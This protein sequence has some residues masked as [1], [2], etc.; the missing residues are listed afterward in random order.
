[1][2]FSRLG[3]VFSR[4][5]SLLRRPLYLLSVRARIATLAFSP[6]LGFMIIGLAY[7]VGEHELESAFDSVKSAS[8]LADVSRD[9]KTAIGTM[10]ITA[11]E[12][13]AQPETNEIKTFSEAYAAALKSLESIEVGGEAS[14]KQGVG[15]LRQ[16]LMELKEKF[17]AMQ[18]EAEKLGL[19]ANEG[20]RGRV[21]KNSAAVERI[22]NQEMSWLSDADQKKLLFSLLIMRRYEADYRL[23]RQDIAHSMFFLEFQNFNSALGRMNAVGD[24]IA[25]ASLLKR[26][27]T[28]QVRS[29]ADT[30]GEWAET[31]D[32]VKPS[33]AI[34]ELDSAEMLPAADKIIA[35]AGQREEE[36]TARFDASQMRTKWIILSA[37]FA[38][39]LLGLLLSWLIGRSIT[40]PLGGLASAM[41][42]LAEGNLS[43]AVP[44]ARASDE[45]G[46]MAR[47]VLVFRDN[48]R[49]R[50]RLEAEQQHTSAEREA[51]AAAVERLVRGFAGTADLALDAVKAAA[52]KLGIAA[53]G[54]GET[55]GR[56]GSEAEQAGRAAGAA[57]ANVAQAA[58][59]AEQ[60]A[61]SV[62]EV[63][64]QTA[65]S[66]EV[67]GRAV[68][69]T[70]RSVGIM[71]TLAEAASR[72]GEVVGLIQ[73][74]AAQTNLLALNATIEAARAGEAGRGFAVV[75]AEVKSLA[76]QTAHATEE[77]TYQ[78]NAIQEASFEARRAIDTVSSVIQEMSAMA[79]SIAS[80]VEEQN[81]AVVSIANNVALASNEADVGAN[82]MR[83][84]EHAASGARL[85]ASDVAALAVQLGGEAENLNAAIGKFLAEVRAA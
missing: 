36:A 67:A 50:D 41:K 75:A 69:E 52:N 19:S 51:H 45:I 74:I 5:G 79:A 42:S 43:A 7:V 46:A 23:N 82:A 4:L 44:A 70:Q 38:V 33:L 22:I 71:G 58:A 76:N 35:L 13:A 62:A 40:R 9:F 15:S 21:E 32:R 84:V 10:R 73:S 37:G 83:G 80:A 78:I 53:D 12:F 81:M 31:D 8:A 6:V 57:S 1:M 55:A 3:S 18:M 65:S 61:G 27:L 56:V 68:T 16:R 24:K 20:L 77:I 14:E 29:Y 48:A 39:A 2:D 17:S 30:F 72:I 59:A 47:A 25:P 26:Q 49:E 64:R 34:I 54:L 66:T 60:L 28:E 85:T 63:A 11:K